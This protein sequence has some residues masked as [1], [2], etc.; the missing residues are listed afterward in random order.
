MI[1]MS[2]FGARSIVLFQRGKYLKSILVIPYVYCV[3]FD[4]QAPRF[5]LTTQ[6][7]LHYYIKVA[8]IGPNET[9]SLQCLVTVLL[10][11]YSLAANDTTMNSNQLPLLHRA[12][13]WLVL[14]TG[15]GI[16]DITAFICT[17]FSLSRTSKSYHSF[18]DIYLYFQ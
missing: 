5:K 15:R 3:K 9:V 1:I 18:C 4:M 16:V 14:R 6:S 11:Q 2:Q 8:F 10:N 12:A 17:E 13:R 7:I